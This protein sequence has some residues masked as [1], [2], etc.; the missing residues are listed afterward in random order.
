[1]A[2]EEMDGSLVI[3]NTLEEDEFLYTE[4]LHQVPQSY[5]AWIGLFEIGSSNPRIWKWVDGS[6]P[7]F[8]K[9]GSTEPSHSVANCVTALIEGSNR[10]WNDRRCK[11]HMVLFAKRNRTNHNSTN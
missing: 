5:Q 8:T 7:T 3:S 11:K 2:C 6:V 10:G 4:V 9:W 1:M